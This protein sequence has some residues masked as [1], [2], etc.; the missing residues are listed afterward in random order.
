MYWQKNRKR[1][2][3]KLKHELIVEIYASFNCNLI[4]IYDIILTDIKR[5]TNH[6]S[7]VS[8]QVLEK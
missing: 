6:A 2:H 4:R 3:V 8:N 1:S 5:H 7:I